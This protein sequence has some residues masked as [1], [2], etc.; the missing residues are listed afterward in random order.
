METDT[1]QDK[2]NINDNDFDQYYKLWN[3]YERV[4]MH[5][6]ELIIRLRI[7]SIGG[8][9]ALATVLGIVLKTNNGKDGTF[10]YFLATLALFFLICCWGAICALDLGYYNR[11]LEGSVNAILE[12]EKKRGAFLKKKEICLSTNIEK[13]LKVRFDHEIN[14]TE[15]IN[16]RKWFYGIVLIALLVIFV[17]T[18]C[19]W[20]KDCK[21][22]ASAPETNH[23]T[24]I[25]NE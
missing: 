4:A 18:I 15:I 14:K 22:K 1:E 6:N 7:Q 24:Q 20:R 21:N 3:S 25:T 5:F 12:L 11:L 8:L 10:N 16:G 17:S 2:D 19:M 13:A 23:K 9:A